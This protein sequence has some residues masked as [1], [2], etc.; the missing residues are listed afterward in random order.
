MI[1]YKKCRSK[2]KQKLTQKQARFVLALADNGLRVGCAA[3]E[4]GICDTCGH[5]HR[6]AIQEKTGLDPRDYWDMTKLI[7]MAMKILVDEQEEPAQSAAQ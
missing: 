4:L 5:Q 7:E 3:Q 1:D 2:R 6:R